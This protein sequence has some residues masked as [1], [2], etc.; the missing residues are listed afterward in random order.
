MRA[1]LDDTGILAIV[2]QYAPAVYFHPEESARGVIVPARPTDVPMEG[3]PRCGGPSSCFHWEHACVDASHHTHEKATHRRRGAHAGAFGPPTAG[4]FHAVHDDGNVPPSPDPPFPTR[5]TRAR[6]ACSPRRGG[7]AAP[8]NARRARGMV[9][10][11][12]CLFHIAGKRVSLGSFADRRPPRAGRLPRDDGRAPADPGGS[13]IDR[14]PARAVASGAR[15]LGGDRR[16]HCGDPS[17]CSGTALAPRERTGRGVAGI[18]RS[19]YLI[20]QRI[21]NGRTPP[22]KGE[23]RPACASPA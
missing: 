12:P 17:S 11:A 5:S 6:T 2:Q 23:V 7:L 18:T 13:A 10:P 20:P 4:A 1:S 22:A 16:A 15:R 21:C 9:S 3:P 8:A 19:S 14:R